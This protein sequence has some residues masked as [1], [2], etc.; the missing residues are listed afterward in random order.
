MKIRTRLLITSLLLFAAGSYWFVDW[1]LK[2]FRYHYFMT[3]E[4]SMVDTATVLSALAAQ[5]LDRDAPVPSNPFQ[6]GLSEAARRTLSAQIYDFSKTNMNLRVLL[7]DRTGTVIF[8]SQNHEAEGADH[9]QWRDVFLTLRGEYGARATLKDPNDPDSLMFYVGA[10]V[11][12][13]GEIRGALSVGKPIS[14][15]LPFLRKA[16]L[17][18][19]VTG[20]TV[21]GAVMLMQVLIAFWVTRPVHRLTAYAR[22]VRDGRK[23][24]RPPLAHSE[25]GDL[26]TA[27]EEMRDALEGREYVERYVQS[28]THE[29]KSPLAAIRGASEL[30]HEEMPEEQ[31]R[32]FLDNIQTETQRAHDLIDRLLALAGLEKRKHLEYAGPVDL[33]A[34]IGDVLRSLQP[35]IHQKALRIVR[36]D[37]PSARLFGETF[38]LRQAIANLLQNALDF[39]PTGGTVEIETAREGRT[40]VIRICD[41]GPGIPDYALDRIF[42]RFYSLPR[43]DHG[44][45]SSGLGLNFVRETAHLHGGDV[46]I[47]NRT[48]HGVEALLSLPAEPA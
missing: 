24:P 27:F 40:A 39:S 31:R 2:D 13:Q 25:M 34:L 37:G 20:L 19:I 11:L 14:S 15:I 45:K 28:L 32:R 26:A 12:V 47:A 38:L 33:S 29:M 16:K 22:A 10:P 21:V 17:S 30:L 42:E 18:L 4:E 48:P 8:D 7:T 35:V 43:P 6:R 44:K 1:M 23:I 46:R 3:M 36:R 41:E 5:Q 9:S